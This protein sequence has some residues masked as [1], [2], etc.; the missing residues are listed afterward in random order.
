[1]FAQERPHGFD[2]FGSQGSTCIVIKINAAHVDANFCGMAV[3]AMTD[4]DL[5]L[6][7]SPRAGRPCH[8]IFPF[9]TRVFPFGRT[10]MST[11]LPEPWNDSEGYTGCR[12]PLESESKCCRGRTTDPEVL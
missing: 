1:M 3:P 10:P 9:L 2:D 11:C 6:N 7:G 5:V 8:R 12:R 4:L